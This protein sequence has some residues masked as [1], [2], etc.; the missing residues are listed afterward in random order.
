MQP[1]REQLVLMAAYLHGT[2][3]D[4]RQEPTANCGKVL[5]HALLWAGL[6]NDEKHRAFFHGADADNPVA[7]AWYRALIA[8]TQVEPDSDRLLEGSGNLGSPD[9]DPPAGPTFTACGLTDKR[10]ALAEQLFAPL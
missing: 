10:H 5:A 2:P 8:L 4:K 1:T 6:W 9:G 3:R 7:D